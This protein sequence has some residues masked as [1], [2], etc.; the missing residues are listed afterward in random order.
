MNHVMFD[1]ET[2]GTLPGSALR[3]IGAI[4]F[5]PI[6]NTLGES[7]YRNIDK[8]SCLQI[9]LTTDPMTEAWWGRQSPEAVAALQNDQ[10]SIAEVAVG[11]NTWFGAN[12]GEFIWCHGASF[13][14]PLWA[15]VEPR[16]SIA[17]AWRYWN[18][19]C[20]RTLY[21]VA[22]FDPRTVVREGV[23]HNALDDAIYQAR[24][25]QHAWSRILRETRD[26]K[27]S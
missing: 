3:S 13:D 14:A 19:R 26:T 12:G 1:L 20:T 10:R 7:F 22:N 8:G 9:G 21:A 4:F 25:V 27:V 16:L 24:C 6:S 5:D 11:F 2:W 17:P 23:A 15:A 18:V